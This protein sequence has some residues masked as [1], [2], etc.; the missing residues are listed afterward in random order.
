M[1]WFSQTIYKFP[2]NYLLSQ[3]LYVVIFDGPAFCAI[4]V[5]EKSEYNDK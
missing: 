3:S 1:I 4:F 5:A 2:Q